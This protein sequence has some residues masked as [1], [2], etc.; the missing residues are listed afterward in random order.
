MVSKESRVKICLTHWPI[1]YLKPVFLAN[2][3]I[4]TIECKCTKLDVLIRAKIL[5]LGCRKGTDCERLGLLAIIQ[6]LE[7]PVP[8]SSLGIL[9]NRHI[10]LHPSPSQMIFSQT[11]WWILLEL[12][13]ETRSSRSSR[14]YVEKDRLKM[15]TYNIKHSQRNLASKQLWIR[16]DI[17]INLSCF[18]RTLFCFAE[19][20]PHI[21]LIL[22]DA[23]GDPLSY[24]YDSPRKINGKSCPFF[25]CFWIC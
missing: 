5:I 23:G 13:G 20:K 4:C 10:S 21:L 14:E 15:L 22:L 6:L 17:Q 8:L 1:L 18:Q 24:F 19:I 7:L 16:V 2:F 11:K 9:Y 12:K 3:W 25:Y